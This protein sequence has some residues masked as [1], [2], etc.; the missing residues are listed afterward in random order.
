M[1]PSIRSGEIV[2]RRLNP[3]SYAAMEELAEESAGI[4]LRAGENAFKIPV[5]DKSVYR[6][7]SPNIYI[8][9]IY[10]KTCPIMHSIHTRKDAH[11]ENRIL[12]KENYA[13]YFK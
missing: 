7:V 1:N 8:Q 2:L 6:E 4:G 5:I 13:E 12:S 3:D 11:S 10:F 9:S